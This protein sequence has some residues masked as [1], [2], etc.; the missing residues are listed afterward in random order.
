MCATLGYTKKIVFQAHCLYR[1][2]TF[3]DNV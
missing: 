1:R 2:A 3:F